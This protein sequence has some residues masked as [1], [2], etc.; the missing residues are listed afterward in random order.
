MEI[1]FPTMKTEDPHKQHKIF[2]GIERDSIFEFDEFTTMSE[3]DISRM[4]KSVRG[5]PIPLSNMSIRKLSSLSRLI[6]MSQDS[7]VKRSHLASFL[8]QR[9][10][11][12]FNKG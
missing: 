5:R 12:E 4:T 8:Y 3:T 11:F 9:P 6:T 7:N 2:E 1:I 10:A